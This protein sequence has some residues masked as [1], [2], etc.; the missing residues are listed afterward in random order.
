MTLGFAKL[1][2][3][4]AGYANYGLHNDKQL[5]QTSHH[6]ANVMYNILAGA[7]RKKGSGAGAFLV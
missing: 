7:K 3:T 2:P 1:T 4:Y 6:H 5:P